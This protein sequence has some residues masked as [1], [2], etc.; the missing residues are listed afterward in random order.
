MKTNSGNI[1]KR[2]KWLIALGAVF[3]VYTI[4]GFFVVPAV[5][6][7]QMLKILPGLTKRQ[8]SVEKVKFNPF[9][10]SLTIDGF[11]LKETNGDVFSSFGELYVN[12][13]LSSIFKRAFVFD[14]ISLRDPF[15]QAIY[16]TNGT[17]NFANLLAGPSA[18]NAPAA[19]A[20]PAEPPRVVIYHL[21]VTNGAVAFEDFTRP[22][23]FNIRYQPMNVSLSNLTTI[24]NGHG[25]YEIA[26][27]GDSG[28]SFGWAGSV[29]VNPLRSTGSFRLTGLKL[30]KFQPY[31]EDFARFDIIDGQVDAAA[32][33]RYDST[34]NALDFEVTNASMRLSR[35][36]LKT[37]DTGEEVVTIP[38]LSIERVSAAMLK[39]SAE[40]GRIESSGGALLVRRNH[41]GTLNLLSALVSHPSA[42]STNPPAPAGPPWTAKIDEIAFNSYAVVAEDKVPAK[43]ATFRIDQLAF[44]LKNI[45]NI[46]NA[47]VAIALSLRLEDTGLIGVAGTT[48]L[49]PPSADLQ[50]GV[51]NLDVRLVQSYLQEHANLALARGGIYVDGRAHY[52]TGAD[53]APLANFHGDVSVKKFAVTDEVRYD[54]MVSWDALDA[55]GIQFDLQPLKIH[56]DKLN[57]SGARNT[58]II[59]PDHRINV[60]TILP[61][62]TNTPPVAAAKAPPA[63][64]ALPDL[65]VDEF[66]FDGVS[67]HFADRSIEPN[68]TFDV[69]ESS[70]SVKNISSLVQTPSPV[71]MKGR[72][73]QFSSFSVTG[74]L[75]PMPDKLFIK[76]AFDM[77]NTG[78]TGL[79]PYTEKYVGRPLEKGK[80]SFALDYHIDHRAL[81]ASNFVFI[82]QLTL[83]A[84]NDSTNAT[85]LPVKLAI[86]LLKDRRGRITLDVPVHGSLDDPKFKVGPIIWGVVKNLIVKAATSPFSL[87]G[88]MF[89]G[90]AE[91]SYVAFDPGRADV[92]PAENK[93][94]ET[95]AR[96]LYERPELTMEINGSADP[97]K[98]REVMQHDRLDGQLKALYV[99]GLMASG[100][101][102]VEANEVTLTPADYQHLV[103]E[104]YSNVFGAVQTTTNAPVTVTPP[105]ATN[106]PPALPQKSPASPPQYRHGGARLMAFSAA[107]TVKQIQSPPVPPPVVVPVAAAPPTNGPVDL[108]TMEK[109][110]EQKID[111]TSDDYLQLM[112]VRANAVEACLLKTG[113]VT[114]DRLF[115]T[116]PKPIKPG[117][118]GEDRVNL[119]LD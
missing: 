101:P 119:K 36:Q 105:A 21:L 72:I 19:P 33:Y 67:L 39:H 106:P 56:L 113:K 5:V 40:V 11:S 112:K 61:E 54:E 96:A 63:P 23:P 115:L 50:I 52:A 9:A 86:A 32:D 27:T 47:P 91:L 83:G 57:F 59:G 48:T 20:K 65:T 49:L 102:P 94:I 71:E 93:K 38:T 99:K 15:A 81:N 92:P 60:L 17:F 87:L 29:T 46:T 89:G 82:D 103:P 18:T 107:P 62:R 34:T 16:F 31:S 28:E 43:P 79:S 26:V 12:F 85:H 37:Q 8:V 7:S 22:T 64:N 90:G 78:L 45:S 10:L 44:D 35:F 97:A 53:G 80:L 117:V 58:V 95:L 76:L 68:S 24:R 116:V 3:L 2:T 88:S 66:S 55:D 110:L 77:T 100:K 70:G 109:K 69:L 13:Q 73:D 75:N 51:T 98:D 104:L 84:K 30:K 74:T 4:V 25:P 14:E 41:D 42:P 118:P 108:A 6:K 111:I 114:A 1:P